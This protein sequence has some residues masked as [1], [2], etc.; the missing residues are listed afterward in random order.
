MK[1]VGDTV[2]AGEYLLFTGGSYSSFGVNGLYR[3]RK[4]FVIPGKKRPGWH[5]GRDMVPDQGAMSSDP[6]LLEEIE[7]AEIWQDE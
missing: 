4:A 1:K 6:E 2:T 7:Y 3:A 5:G